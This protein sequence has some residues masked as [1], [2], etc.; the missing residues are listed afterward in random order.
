[1]KKQVLLAASVFLF[2]FSGFAQENSILWEVSGKKLEK[3]S[4]LYGTIHIQERDVFDFDPL[5]YKKMKSCDALAVELLMDEIEPEVVREQMLMEDDKLSN[6]LSDQEY[7][8]LDS[9][10]KAK[11]GQ[12]LMLFEKMK[13]FFIM[14]QLMQASM[15]SE[16]PMA[17]DMHLIDTARKMDMEVL[18]LEELSDQIGAIDKMSIEEQVGMLMENIDD[19]ANNIQKQLDKLKKAYLNQNLD[20][21]YML[22]KDTA[23][24]EAFAK[25]L[26]INRNKGMA[27]EMHKLMKKKSVFAAFGAAHLVGEEGVVR[28]LRKKGYTVKPI[29]F[30][31]TPAKF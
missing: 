21:L 10:M 3:P 26:L 18:A 13:P 16:M 31:F 11:T 20:S 14:S 24:P 27:K 19:T 30:E 9:I 8:L 4:Y 25:E 22:T 12:P 15:S 7:E 29:K 17:L 1:M 23:L 6:Y 5:I 28:L 2:I